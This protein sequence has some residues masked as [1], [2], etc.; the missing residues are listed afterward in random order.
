MSPHSNGG[1]KMDRERQK[2]K[3]RDR[4]INDDR[5]L[6]RAIRIQKEHWFWPDADD[7]KRHQSAVRWKDNLKKCSCDMCGNSRRHF[8]ERTLQEKKFDDQMK[9]EIDEFLSL[10]EKCQKKTKK[11]Y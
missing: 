5:M 3:A 11:S 8:G 7:E 2:E 10:G 4:R 1:I 6:R 9:I